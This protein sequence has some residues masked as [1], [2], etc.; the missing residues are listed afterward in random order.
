MKRFILGTLAFIVVLLF[1]FFIEGGNP[2]DFL[3][4]SPLII[5]VCVPAFAI[6]AVW[7]LKD[8]GRAWKDAFVK[9]GAPRAT[10][11]AA[12]SAKLWDFYEKACYI[13]GIVG[14]ILGLNI[15]FQNK[16]NLNGEIFRPLAVD[17]VAPI[18]AIILAMVARIMKARVENNAR[19][20]ETRKQANEEDHQA[21]R[22]R[23]IA[24]LTLVAVMAAGNQIACLSERSRMPAPGKIVEASG[25]RMHVYTEGRGEKNVVLLS[26]LGSPCP[27]IDFKPLTNAL[28]NYK[29]TVADYPG[30]GWSD[31]SDRPRTTENIVEET[32]AAL[33]KAGINLDTALRKSMSTASR[34]KNRNSTA[35]SEC[36]GFSA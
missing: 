19:E 14:F 25:A 21:D 2:L 24:L 31:L 18:L 30:Y 29:V 3:L 9:A 26:G 8:W 28:D 23:R 15:I 11:S 6:L 32:R 16:G 34:R 4:P 35:P 1:A 33:A 12:V 13:A 10:T 5:V 22:H 36:R 27:V 20:A 17:C 7:S